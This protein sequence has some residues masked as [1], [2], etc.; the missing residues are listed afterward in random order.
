MRSGREIAYINPIFILNSVDLAME[1]GVFLMP[2]F[3]ATK[4]KNLKCSINYEQKL[5]NIEEFRGIK[6]DG[7]NFAADRLKHLIQFADS[8]Y[9]IIC[10]RS[11]SINDVITFSLMER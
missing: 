6:A 8:K 1:V 3:N 10:I 9:Q 4:H 7:N 2:N 5:E 11:S